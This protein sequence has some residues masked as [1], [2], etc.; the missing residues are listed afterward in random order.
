MPARRPC[1][2]FG[3]LRPHNR[4]QRWDWYYRYGFYTNDRDGT[5]LEP[6]PGGNPIGRR[7]TM[8]DSLAV[9]PVKG[10]VLKFVA[11]IDHPDSDVKPVH[12]RV[13][14]DSK[15]VYEGDLQRAAADAR[16]S[17]DA[18]QD[19]HAD[20]DVDR[21]HVAPERCGQ[22]RH[23]AISGLSIRDWVWE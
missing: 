4:A 1:D 19:A 15:L 20:R 18:G 6:D 8:K 23:V 3:D 17:S 9:I 22:P 14:A 10:K 21:S 12:A 7:W 11:W 5:D 2:A 16:H 13:W